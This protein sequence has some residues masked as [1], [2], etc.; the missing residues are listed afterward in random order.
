MT[1]NLLEFE[2]QKFAQFCA[3]LGEK[4]FRAR[5]LMHW[6]HQSG[7]D[8]FDAMTDIAKPL[9]ERL[10]AD[11]GV[12]PPRVISDTTAADGT[13]K[14]LLDVN[15]GNAIET[16][17]IP[18]RTRSTLCVSSQAGCAL[19]CSFCSTGRQGFNRNLSLSEIIGQL[20]LANRSLA[21]AGGD[22]V[23]RVTNVVMMGMGEPLANFDNVVAAMHLMLDDDAY[24][25]SRRR[26]TL[27]TSGLVP[28][29]D[30][31]GDAC[32][33]AL[34]VSLHAP[35]DQLRDELVPINKKYPLK[36]LMAACLRYIEKAPRD[37]VTF[38]YVMLDG[39]ND[40]Y[41]HARELVRLVSP[42]PCKINLIPFNPF[43]DSGYTRSGAEAVARFRDVLMAASLTVTVRR[44][45]G[46]DIDAAC[47]QL[48]GRVQDRTR[49]RERRTATVS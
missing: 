8:D 13:R 9:R 25:L 45:R 31:L 5:Q 2:K 42:V 46:D 16:V 48:A 36:Q 27:S 26:V 41:E 30:R 20:W 40:S 34:A 1:V 39:V 15:A 19:E 4:P 35:N 32:P 17:F 24:G 33:V 3:E 28:Q 21:A 49:R 10:K 44:T 37:F 47:G 11:C 23:R 43:P 14:W 7:V 12:I 22:D 6:I 29:M 38:E 18:E